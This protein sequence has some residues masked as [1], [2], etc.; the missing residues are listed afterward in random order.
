MHQHRALLRL[1]PP[2]AHAHQHKPPSS[3]V[4]EHS[5]AS[6]SCVQ[7]TTQRNEA[8]CQWQHPYERKLLA[9]LLLLSPLLSP[10]HTHALLLHADRPQ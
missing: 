5:L 4:R 8:A 7:V 3:P 9:L 10:C 1:L 6:L 2:C